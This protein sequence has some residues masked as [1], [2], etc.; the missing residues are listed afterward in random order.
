MPW[1]GERYINKDE[2]E[3]VK[4]TKEEEKRYLYYIS[5]AVEV[6]T[7]RKTTYKLKDYKNV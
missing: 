7:P 4:A 1:P 2:R 6:M 5:R 3:K